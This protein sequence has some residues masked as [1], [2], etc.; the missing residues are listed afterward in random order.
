LWN[1]DSGRPGVEFEIRIDDVL[2]GGMLR[3]EFRWEGKKV[4]WVVS[5]SIS[6]DV[7]SQWSVD[8]G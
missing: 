8:S 3:E 1:L 5:V 7:S 2:F 4:G 6:S